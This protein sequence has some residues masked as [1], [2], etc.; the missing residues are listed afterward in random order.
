MSDQRW[1]KVEQVATRFSMHRA[2]L[3]RKVEAGQ[4]P[5]PT[6]IAGMPRWSVEALER[7]EKAQMKKARATG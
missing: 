3:Y 6:K 1:L 4:F 5:R 2:T 7:W